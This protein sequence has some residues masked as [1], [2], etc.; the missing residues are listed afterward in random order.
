MAGARVGKADWAI[1]IACGV[2]LDDP[3]TGVL[4]VSGA[5]AAVV[6]ATICDLGLALTRILAGLV[7]TLDLGIANSVA[8]DH[9]LEGAVL[10]TRARE[11]D[12]SIALTKLSFQHPLTARA[13]R[14]GRSQSAHSGRSAATTSDG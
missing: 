5:D 10:G 3:E 8:I 6:R 2:D 14:L 13:D 7:E 12:T 1:E 11:H 9:C 4:R